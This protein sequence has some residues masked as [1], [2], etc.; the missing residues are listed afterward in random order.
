MVAADLLD[1]TTRCLIACCA[2]PIT[3]TDSVLE[4]ARACFSVIRRA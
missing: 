2:P 1:R 3:E 4:R